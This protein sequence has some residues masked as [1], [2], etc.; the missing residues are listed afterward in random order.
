MP[1]AAPCTRRS[2]FSQGE[3]YANIFPRRGELYAAIAETKWSLEGKCG[4]VSSNQETV[5]AFPLAAGST[6]GAAGEPRHSAAA[7]ARA[8]IEKKTKKTMTRSKVP[9][10]RTP[11]YAIEQIGRFLLEGDSCL[12]GGAITRAITTIAERAALDAVRMHERERDEET[13]KKTV[14]R[15]ISAYPAGYYT[16]VREALA[17]KAASRR[18]LLVTKLSIMRQRRHTVRFDMELDEE[19]REAEESMRGEG[20]LLNPTPGVA[21]RVIYSEG[22]QR[23]F[24]VFL[25][26]EAS[27]KAIA[28]ESKQAATGELTQAEKDAASHL[29]HVNVNYLQPKFEDGPSPFDHGKREV[30]LA[31]LRKTNPGNQLRFAVRRL[32]EEPSQEATTASG[33]LAA[34]GEGQQSPPPSVSVLE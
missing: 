2:I 5:A 16:A 21:S 20:E 13:P 26:A 10:S 18:V 7:R 6:C 15:P 28:S 17:D 9:A 30:S 31:L 33:M 25:S 8:Y 34:S 22:P 27:I 29:V 4:V 14:E 19:E 11:R 3:V 24:N 32:P 23:L 1:E 12:G